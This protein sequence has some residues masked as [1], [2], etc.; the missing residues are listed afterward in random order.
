MIV[1]NKP[2]NFYWE[3]IC[4][5]TQQNTGVTIHYFQNNTLGTITASRNSIGNATFSIT[6]FS[7]TNNKTFVLLS[8]MQHGGGVSCNYGW[9][10]DPNQINIFQNNGTIDKDGYNATLCIKIYP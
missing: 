1:I 5:F 6:G 8:P 4:Y 9:D 7:F 2:S 3:Y 10:I